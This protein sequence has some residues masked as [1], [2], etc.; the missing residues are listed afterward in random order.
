MPKSRTIKGYKATD[1]NGVCQPSQYNCQYYEVGKVY[2]LEYPEHLMLCY[3]GFHFCER[4]YE[5]FCYYPRDR[6][7]RVFEVEALGTVSRPCYGGKYNDTS[8]GK[9]VTDK[10][11]IVRELSRREI[12][13]QL[14]RESMDKRYPE[15][16]RWEAARVLEDLNTAYTPIETRKGDR[17]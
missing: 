5:V 12:L 11:R 3:R 13:D 7:T 17:I 15:W 4:L 14:E 1:E 16:P 8:A 6:F 9:C 2:E 10:I